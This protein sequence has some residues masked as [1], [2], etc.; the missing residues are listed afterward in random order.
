MPN[1]FLYTITFILRAIFKFISK[2]YVE[3]FYSYQMKQTRNTVVS[4]K[5]RLEREDREILIF[6]LFVDKESAFL[7]A[8]LRLTA[9]PFAA[10][11][12]DPLSEEFKTLAGL[13]EQQMMSVY[14]DV[15]DVRDVSVAGFR[16]VV[17]CLDDHAYAFWYEETSCIDRIQA[18]SVLDDLNSF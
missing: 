17:V 7:K 3:I 18:P 8:V 16:Y 2:K 14:R 12:K 4:H 6:R 1:K 13:L 11:L 10:E 15:A 5:F 9:V